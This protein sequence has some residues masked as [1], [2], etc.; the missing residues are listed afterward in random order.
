MV[1]GLINNYF[2]PVYASNED[3]AADGCAPPE[4]KAEHRRIYL[5]TLKAKRTA[6]TVH[7]Y[8]IAP[9]GKALDSM[10]V[11]DASKIEKLT[12]LLENNIKKLKVPEGKPLVKA[13]V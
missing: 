11:A 3:Y 2:V 8:I 6:G 7:V 5:E 9:D 4:E 12:E 10:H 13:T 1:I